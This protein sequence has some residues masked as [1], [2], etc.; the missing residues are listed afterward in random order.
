MTQEI[1]RWQDDAE[2]VEYIRDLSPLERM[3]WF[4]AAPEENQKQYECIKVRELRR[5][6]GV[7][8]M[9]I[10][11][12]EFGDSCDGCG[13][14]GFLCTCKHCV[15]CKE[16]YAT[17]DMQHG[18]CPDCF[19][20]FSRKD[21]EEKLEYLL[22]SKPETGEQWAHICLIELHINNHA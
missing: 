13:N 14:S 22:S 1:G 15:D 2:W 4:C 8:E 21:L 18:F 20:D 11:H 3:Q 7:R 12:E 10:S 19:D 16:K 17:E 5:D 9:S 6:A